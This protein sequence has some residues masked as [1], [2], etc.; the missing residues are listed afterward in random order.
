MI[1]YLKGTLLHQTDK[2][3]VICNGVGYGVF[4]SP[5]ILQQLQGVDEAELYIHTHV[6]EEALDLFGFLSRDEQSL[7][8]LLI[9]VSGVGPKTALQ[10]SN[11]SPQEIISAVQNAETTLFSSVPRVG[12]KLAQKIIIELRG[13]LGALKELDLEPLAPQLQEV[14]EALLQLG[15]RETDVDQ[16]LPQ[17]EINEKTT[18]SSA[19][20]LAL[21]H[22][23]Q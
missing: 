14:K 19:I 5:R 22:L 2:V 1:A 17:L 10:I 23:A 20:K 7:F 11:Y 13:K 3:I 16:V 18:T 6:R 8:E 9:S 15:F 12:K 21:Q 4:V